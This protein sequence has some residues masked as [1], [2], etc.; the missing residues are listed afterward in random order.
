MNIFKLIIIFSLTL[1]HNKAAFSNIQNN[2]S[3]TCATNI[4]VKVG[5]INE[6]ANLGG[7]SHFIEHMIFKGDG[8]LDSKDVSSAFD[9]VGAYINA[10]TT[11]DHTCYYFK[12]HSDYLEKCLNVYSKIL[13]NANMDKGEF[14]KEKNVVVD[15]IIRSND[16]TEGLVNEKIY[17]LIFKGSSLQNPI[18]GRQELIEKYDYEESIKF[19]KKHENLPII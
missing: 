13:I 1:F 3:Q 17:E 4:F 19:Y 12:S 8:T 5:S 18:G 15:E 7:I 9:S 11:F 6:H 2:N 16:N 10:Y 14:D